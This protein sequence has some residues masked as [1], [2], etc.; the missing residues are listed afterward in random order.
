M[1]RRISMIALVLA[2]IL[3]T[4]TM[5]CGQHAAAATAPARGVI[6]A[7]DPS[8]IDAAEYERAPVTLD[9]EVLFEVRGFSAYPAEE[10]AKT[11]EKRIK[12]IAAD[13]SAA[14]ESLRVDEMADRTRIMAGDRLLVAFVDADAAAAEGV[15][16]QLLA[17]RVLI[18]IRTAN[19]LLPQ[20]SQ[21]TCLADQ[22]SVRARRNGATGARAARRTPHIHQAG[23]YRRAALQVPDRSI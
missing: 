7:T 10:R 21:S 4:L 6:A 18:K 2:T 17:E 15:T 23:C 13:R 22:H 20:C 19:R 3:G 11:I 8:G 1:H 12:E 5:S 16:R 14:I 9:G